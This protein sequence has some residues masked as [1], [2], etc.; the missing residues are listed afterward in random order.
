M[1]RRY[2][3]IG[4]LILAL[5]ALASIPALAADGD[6]DP[7]FGIGGRVSYWDPSGGWLSGSASAIQSDGKIIV[8]GSIG[9]LEWA[10]FVL[11]RFKADGSLDTTFGI[12]GKVTTDFGQGGSTIANAI[13]IQPDGKIL[14]AGEAGT[15]S[16]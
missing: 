7:T 8:A 1:T 11:T 4:V 14:A 12:G 6:L 10:D 13:A 9:G 3:M 2:F 15:N 16:N 5:A